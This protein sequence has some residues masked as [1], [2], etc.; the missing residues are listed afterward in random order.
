[1]VMHYRHLRPLAVYLFL[2]SLAFLGVGIRFLPAISAP[3][4]FGGA[5]GAAFLSGILRKRGTQGILPG[6]FGLFLQFLF[7]LG[8]FFLGRGLGQDMMA[9]TAGGLLLGGILIF[10][11]LPLLLSK[12]FCRKVTEERVGHYRPIYDAFLPT[13]LVGDAPTC[14]FCRLSPQGRLSRLAFAALFLAFGS[15]LF[16]LGYVIWAI[17]CLLFSAFQMMDGLLRGVFWTLPLWGL[18]ALA[19]L[20]YRLYLGGNAGVLLWVATGALGLV[21]VFILRFYFVGLRHRML[22]SALLFE[23]DAWIGGVGAGSDDPQLAMTMPQRSY[24]LL[25]RICVKFTP[26]PGC[27]EYYFRK[28]WQDLQ[29]F[30]S[31]RGLFAAG[32]RAEKEMPEVSYY[33]YAEKAETEAAL[34]KFAAQTQ[35][36][37]CTVTKKPDP[38][39]SV[40]LAL[41]PTTAELAH[42]HHALLF[43]CVEPRQDQAF[44]LAFHVL[45]KTPEEADRFLQ[46]E[47]QRYEGATC[48]P[49]PLPFLLRGFMV[50]VSLYRQMTIAEDQISAILQELSLKADAAGGEYFF[51]EITGDAVP[52]FAKEQRDRILSDLRAAKEAEISPEV[53]DAPQEAGAAPQEAESA[54]QETEATPQE[55]EISPE[56]EDPASTVLPAPEAPQQDN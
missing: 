15:A 34:C 17:P 1:M 35:H 2:L 30:C 11:G 37:E 19:R 31:R 49:P 25:F 46:E 53:E 38:E 48:S 23:R 8:G 28:R 45:F 26:F 12:I 27:E 51:W 43:S 13:V 47:A 41:L 20:L 16:S 50:C 54:P 39:F 6:I 44:S 10:S 55:T 24:A 4:Y 21:S 7:L 32:L 33:V 9:F 29:I 40:F 42:S 22:P 5:L 14:A 56:A 18:C 52:D 36:T 3:F